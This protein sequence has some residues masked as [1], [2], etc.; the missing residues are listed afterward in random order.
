MTWIE[1]FDGLFSNIFGE[2]YLNYNWDRAKGQMI[3]SPNS[4]PT[5]VYDHALWEKSY[6]VPGSNSSVP[7][8]VSHIVSS[9]SESP[10][11][12]PLPPTSQSA[13]VISRPVSGTTSSRCNTS[14]LPCSSLPVSNIAT[15]TY[16]ADLMVCATADA[17]R[18]QLSTLSLPPVAQ[19]PDHCICV[20]S[21]PERLNN[22]LQ[23]MF[24]PSET[25]LRKGY[26]LIDQANNDS[27]SEDEDHQVAVKFGELG[28]FDC[29]AIDV[30][31][32]ACKASLTKM[33]VKEEEKW[34]Q[35][36][37]GVLTAAQIH[38][39]A[40]LLFGS[41]PEQEILRVKDVFVDANDISALVGERY[42]NGFLIDALCLKYS[43]EAILSGS[44]S[45]YLPSLT[46][47]WVSSGSLPHLKSKLKPYLSGRNLA[48]I[49]WI[50]SPVHVN[51]N[52]W[53]LLCLNM[54]SRQVFYDDGLKWNCP[55][56]VPEI[57]RKLL[58]AIPCNPAASWDETAPPQRFGMPNQPLVGEGCGSCGVGV[59]LA[60]YDFLNVNNNSVPIF[61][62]KFADMKKHRQKL[63]LQTV[64]WNLHS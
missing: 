22:P 51:G 11:V 3:I 42:L 47:T 15:T 59:V 6:P 48:G 63:L 54:A 45:L 29:R 32:S 57:V 8:S 44:T 36:S 49:H 12:T 9:S 23:L 58:Q 17:T 20:V 30:L 62:W 10:V 39:I 27:E 37:N 61:Q 43:E 7:C 28:V 31:I 46:Q 19:I 21:D 56:D 5:Y 34:L 52:H 18:G 26:Q 35:G 16:V 40:S 25:A 33:R 13:S 64:Q 41:K 55:S 24:R 2:D 50:L 60:T 38:E 4:F 1:M 14:K 53:G